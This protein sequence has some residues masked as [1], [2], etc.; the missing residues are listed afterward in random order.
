MHSTAFDTFLALLDPAGTP[1]AD[2]D[3]SST[4][5]TDSRITFTLTTS[6]TWTIFAN[7][8]NASKTGDYN[9]L[10]SCGATN[11]ARRRAVRH[12]SN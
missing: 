9:L 5:S 3:D 2:S 10:L 6:G 11:A 4:S 12:G 8:L 7:S 1:V